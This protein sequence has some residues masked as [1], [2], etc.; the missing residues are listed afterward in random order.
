MKT[1]LTR[2]SF[3]GLLGLSATAAS[4]AA[5]SGGASTPAAGGATPAPKTAEKAAPANGSAK[6]AGTEVRIGALVP[7]TGP[8]AEWGRKNTI[9]LEMLQDEVNSAGGVNGVPLKMF[10]RDTAQKPEQAANLLRQLAS[11]DRVLAVAGPLFSGECEVV[12]PIANQLKIVSTSQASSKPGVAAANR[13][14]AFRNTMDESKLADAAAA[15]FI[16]KHNIKKVLVAYDV[17]DATSTTLGKQVLPTAFKAKGIQL[18]NESDPVTFSTTDNDFSAQVTKLKGLGG[19][20]LLLGADYGPG[21]AIIAEM[22]RQGW[23][24]PVIS[25]TTMLAYTVLQFTGKVP[26]MVPATYF[27]GLP[28]PKVQDFNNRFKAR[29]SSIPEASRDT[30][31]YEANIYDIVQIYLEAIKK[32]G[33]TNKPEDLASDRDK[34]R[35]YMSTLKNYEGVA[36]KISFDEHG[37]GIKD[38]YVLE[39]VD[40][41]WQVVK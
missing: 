39:A 36:G 33:V 26:L 16:A 7:S 25:G 5:C 34:I 8:N 24:V 38:I 20:G 28:D 23:T 12:F 3:L 27:A 35:A 30:S 1:D 4:L 21:G 15:K 2:R 13:P 32:N 29:A 22:N 9:L 41:K 14:W 31:Q 19:D 6:L 40:A 10:V 17:K 37:D 18:V 11:D